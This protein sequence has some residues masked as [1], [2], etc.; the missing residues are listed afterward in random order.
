MV[1][2]AADGRV[3][4]RALLAELA[5]RGCNDVLFECGARLAGSVLSAGLVD[6]LVTYI[7]GVLLGHAARPLVELAPASLAAAPRFDLVDST[8]LGADV[9]L[10]WRPA[11]TMDDSNL[12][13]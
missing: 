8:P 11:G 10:R 4:L 3:D 9:R 6:E 1:L 7:A 2:P 13:Q 5:A 12:G